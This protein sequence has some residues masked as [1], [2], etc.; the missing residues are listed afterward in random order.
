MKKI[1]E[2]NQTTLIR[3][4]EKCLQ[5]ARELFDEADIL[6]DHNKYARAYTL[7]HLSIEEIG[8]IFIIFQYLLLDNYS[9]D[10]TK[11]FQ[12]EF[13]DHK[14]KIKISRNIEKI[15]LFVMQKELK[16]EEFKNL[17][18][19]KEQIEELNNFKNLSLYTFIDNK[20]VFKPSDLI[21][22]DEINLIRPNSEARLVLSESFC[23]LAIKDINKFINAVKENL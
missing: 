3:C 6:K 1:Q 2:I 5:N 13:A 10:N 16:E 7:Y 9:E 11:K 22:L 18:Y 12:R 23:R 15:M 17:T 21:G 4:V 20:R 8:K 14:T 19:S